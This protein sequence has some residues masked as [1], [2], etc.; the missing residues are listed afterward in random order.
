MTEKHTPVATGVCRA[1]R[2]S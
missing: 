2:K 1:S